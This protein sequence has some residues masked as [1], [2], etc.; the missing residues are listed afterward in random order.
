MAACS[1]TEHD[2]GSAQRTGGIPEIGPWEWSAAEMVFRSRKMCFHVRRECTR[3]RGYL[4][5]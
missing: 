3:A 2:R 5:T 1:R 4:D